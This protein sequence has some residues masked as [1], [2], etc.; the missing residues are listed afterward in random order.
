MSEHNKKTPDSSDNSLESLRDLIADLGLTEAL[1]EYVAEGNHPEWDEDE[2]PPT[3]AAH[4]KGVLFGS[5]SNRPKRIPAAVVSYLRLAPDTVMTRSV[6]REILQFEARQFGGW[7]VT[8]DFRKKP[9]AKPEGKPEYEA[10]HS[11]GYWGNDEE[12][13]WLDCPQELIPH[14]L[15]WLMLREAD[16]TVSTHLA[17]LN[18]NAQ[19]GHWWFR[20]SYAALFAGRKLKERHPIVDFVPANNQTREA[21]LGKEVRDFV[22]SLPE[23]SVQRQR[24][25]T[26]IVSQTVEKPDVD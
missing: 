22:T 24:A 25:A 16:G 17:E 7:R 1:G 3:F 6:P 8:L 19:T 18:F 11:E 10:G 4:I 15:V 9:A 26:F 23:S 5:T 14:G 21:F 2:V 12:T 20:R 13:I